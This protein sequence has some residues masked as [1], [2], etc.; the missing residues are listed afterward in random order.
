MILRIFGVTRPQGSVQ[1]ISVLSPIY[2][3]GIKKFLYGM[4][5]IRRFR[6]FFHFFFDL[7]LFVFLS[8][9]FELTPC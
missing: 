7:F 6:L 1:I 9:F 8:F 3:L 5:Q 4:A 2:R